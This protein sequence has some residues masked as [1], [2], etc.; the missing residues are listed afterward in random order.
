MKPIKIVKLV[1]LFLLIFLLYE[2]VGILVSYARHPEVSEETKQATNVRTY[3]SDTSETSERATIIEDNSDGLL[4]RVRLIENADTELI[5]SS[6][7][8]HSDESGKIVIGALL[9]AADRGVKIQILVDGFHGFLA[10]ERN[11]YFYA[12]SAHENIEVK[13]YN[14]LNLLT[15]WKLMGRLHDKYL[16]ADGQTYILGGRNTYNY[17]LGDY[18]GIQNHDRDVLV[19]CETPVESSSV[20]Q[21][22]N[23]FEKVWSCSDS[24]AFHEDQKL[25]NRASVQNAGADAKQWYK[26]YRDVHKEAVLDCDYVSDTYETEYIALLTNPIHTGAKEPVMWYQLTE[27]MK[28][29]KSCVRIHTPYIICNNMMYDSWRE[30]AASI[31]EFKIM[32]NSAANNANLFG[33][34]DYTKHK[35][36]ILDTGIEVWEY[37][38][39]NSYHG[40]SILIDD[41]I[42]VIGSFNMDMRSAY[43]DTE[44]MLV[45]RSEEINDQLSGYMQEYETKSRQALPDG[46]Y[47]NP[48]N[49][50]PVEATIGR[51]ISSFLIRNLLNWARFLL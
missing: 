4:Q 51:K 13:L 5:F 28:A 21:L 41:D 8:F 40:K 31:P 2:L 24:K 44:M 27:L 7:S 48:Y 19:Y 16:I 14:P 22:Q 38:G 20:S 39:G 49:I 50:S 25:N 11:P 23:Y 10:M 1:L 46:E 17:F 47:N 35:S 9:N 42:S 30:I 18:P 3:Y 43:L 32:T 15:P 34:A 37:E 29:A 33:S 45:I 12:L 26:E 6:F 36:E